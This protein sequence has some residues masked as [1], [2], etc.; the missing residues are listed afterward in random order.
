[1]RLKKI[2]LCRM[3]KGAQKAVI[4]SI[5]KLINRPTGKK[6]NIII[7]PSLFQEDNRASMHIL[8][9]DEAIS[10]I[11]DHTPELIRV[12]LI[13]NLKYI[14]KEYTG[15]GKY[16]NTGDDPVKHFL[17]LCFSMSNKWNRI[18]ETSDNRT[19]VEQIC[20]ILNDSRKDINK[21]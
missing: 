16:A 5:E 3:V 6:K 1:M 21:K 20:A 9:F 4:K 12:N 14:D 13:E 18:E 11:Q 2:L 10:F 19:Y 15:Y 8:G 17:R 7:S